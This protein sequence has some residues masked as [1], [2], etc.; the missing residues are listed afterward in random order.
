VQN[1]GIPCVVNFGDLYYV[2]LVMHLTRH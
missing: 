2:G 1:K